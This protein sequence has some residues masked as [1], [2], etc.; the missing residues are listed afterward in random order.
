MLR[1]QVIPKRSLEGEL[2]I[3]DVATVQV[4]S[5]QTDHPI[6]HA[7]DPS[8]GPGGS[9]WIAGGPGEQ[10]VTLVFD[11]PQNHPTD[12]DRCGGACRQP[13]PGALGVGLVRYGTDLS[14]AHTTGVQLQPRGQASSAS[15]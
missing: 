9:R 4:T 1:K 15:P 8:G 5:E 6:D 14:R 11:R 7:F 2:S 10:S 3:A 13:H 12:R